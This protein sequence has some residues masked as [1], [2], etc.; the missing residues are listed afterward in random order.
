MLMLT[1]GRRYTG[2]IKT[3]G[4]YTTLYICQA[5]PA[6][7]GA[8]NNIF[9]FGHGGIVKGSH[10][11]FSYIWC[12]ICDSVDINSNIYITM[13]V[14]RCIY[15]IGNFLLVVFPLLPTCTLFPHLWLIIIVILDIFY[16]KNKFL[17]WNIFLFRHC[18][19]VREN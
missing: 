7:G 5:S 18:F 10:P 6:K 8:P 2:N 11:I 13:L 19:E 17:F 9:D 4:G 1:S 3:N 14:R 16:D 15:Y 12:C